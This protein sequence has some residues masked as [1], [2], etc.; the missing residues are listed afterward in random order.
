ML[1]YLAMAVT[2]LWLY[3]EYRAS[4]WLWP[5]GIVLPLLWIVISWQERFYGN[6]IINLYYLV[7]SAWGWFVWLRASKQTTEE[8]PITNISCRPLLMSI[9][10]IAVLFPLAHYL[11][12]TYT[13]SLLPWADTLSTLVSFVGMIWL[14]RKW[15]Q[16]WCCWIIANALS[17]YIFF[18][19]QDYVSTATFLVSFTVAVFG[20]FHWT[21]LMEQDGSSS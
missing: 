15:R 20:F 4:I 16:H 2:F 5:V 8:P 1:T 19:A 21:R 7:T 12:R 14:A 9:G 11:L 10:A 17:A 3:L 13:D 6:V 18:V